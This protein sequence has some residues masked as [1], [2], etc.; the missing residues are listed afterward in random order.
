MPAANRIS[1]STKTRNDEIRCAASA[2][3]SCE[4]RRVRR[5]GLSRHSIEEPAGFALAATSKGG[6][7]KR[8]QSRW[9]SVLG[10][11]PSWD[12]TL[13]ALATWIPRSPTTSRGSTACSRRIRIRRAASCSRRLPV[14]NVECRRRLRAIWCSGNRA[15][16][17][18]Y[19]ILPQLT[20]PC[21]HRCIAMTLRLTGR[22]ARR[23]DDQ[24]HAPLSPAISSGSANI[25]SV[26]RG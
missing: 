5:P 15:P 10:L 6:V 21:A 18:V 13:A 16:P 14:E 2:R 17:R 7:R 26:A 22:H 25:G 23:G 20:A 12:M 9:R 4:S 8:D 24:S 19:E 3:R 1:Q 11:A